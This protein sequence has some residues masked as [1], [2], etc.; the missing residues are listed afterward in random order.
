MQGLW[1]VIHESGSDVPEVILGVDFPVT[2][3]AEAGF[4]ELRA[5]MGDTLTF[6]QTVPPAVSP[7]DRVG[8]DAYV[9]P[10]VDALERA[11]RPVT[12]VF[13]FCVGGVYA[14]A[15]ADA[16]A[17]VQGRRPK[18]ILFD[19][20]YANV[21][22]LSLEL[23]RVLG[24]LGSLLSDEEIEYARGVAETMT[25]AGGDVGDFAAGIAK[26]YREVGAAAFGRVGLG[27]DRADELIRLFESYMSW[28]S[29][30]ERIDPAAAWRDA[31]AITSNN[32]ATLLNRESAGLV[33]QR[34]PFDVEHADLLRSAP[35]AEAVLE[36]LR[37]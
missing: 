21:L 15:V 18:V 33:G 8:G 6:L 20:E 12:A 26:I 27:G 30:A 35:V 37:P 32:T 24:E 23:Q 22:G 14:A 29:V 17:V 28:M 2:G 34:I 10:W 7:L 19:P 4:P 16:V 11:G 36:C 1:S 3:R 5:L 9:R 13:G 25:A 31:V